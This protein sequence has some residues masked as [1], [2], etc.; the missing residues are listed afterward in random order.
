[1]K[2]AAH[3]VDR[4]LR[5]PGA[6]VRAV[7]VYGPDT[8]LVRE[9]TEA[10]MRMAVADLADPF[11]VAEL[12]A[13]GVA[14]DP[15]LLADEAAAIALTGGR[16]A[17][18][19]RDCGDAITE[20]V[21]SMLDRP[22]GD[23]LVVLQA[24]ELGPRST[25]RAFMEKS[26]Q[27]AALPC[28]SDDVRDLDRVIHEALAAES[29]SV[30]PEASAF[31]AANLGSDRGITRAELAKLALYAQ[32]KPRVEL[33]D[34]MAVVGDSAAI[35]LDDL[36]FAVTGGETAALDR[37]LERSFQEGQ[38]DVGVL[39]TVARHLLRLQLAIDK[40]AQGEAFDRILKSFRPPL[41]F[42]RHGEFR[43]QA[44][45]W[46]AERVGRALDFTLA[47]ELSCKSTGIPGAAVCGRTLMQ[48]AALARQGSRARG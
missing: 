36:C 31:L 13:D 5:G 3:D 8:G 33:E 43:R 23:T 45:S 30:S 6:D 41:F 12:A 20:A 24:G 48:I 38:S 46:S 14:K 35:S 40:S 25:L 37:A 32:G 11:L 47:A 9:R 44:Q 17:V 27:A 4:F 10:A 21:K 7:L 42:K 2:L 34:A 15:A 22:M 29:L 18:R 16:R 39:R 26:P 1:V 19:V 28:Y